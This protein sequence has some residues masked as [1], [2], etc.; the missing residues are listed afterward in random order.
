MSRAAAASVVFLVLLIGN[1]VLLLRISAFRVDS[2]LKWRYFGVP[3]FGFRAFRA[4][5]YDEDGQRLLPWLWGGTVVQ[6]LAAGIS[7]YLT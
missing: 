4:D 3:A 1:F 2:G 7:F 6:I 5:T